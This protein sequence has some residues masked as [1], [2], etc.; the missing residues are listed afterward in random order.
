MD[1]NFDL[2]DK[3]KKYG[4]PLNAVETKD[5]MPKYVKNNAY[6]IN[7]QDDYVNGIDEMGTHWTG[8]W[9]EDDGAVYFDSFGYIAPANIE[10][11]LYKRFKRYYYN[12]Q[13]IQDMK[14]AYCGS[15][16]LFFLIFMMRHKHL[17]L[18][19]R[20]VAFQSLWNKDTKKNLQILKKYMKDIN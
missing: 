7:L 11:F 14:T 20:L 19:E 13:Q 17:P 18:K 6:I 15:Y 10:T 8:L 5:N 16:V 4:I 9:V 1:S 12:K 3:A 2:I